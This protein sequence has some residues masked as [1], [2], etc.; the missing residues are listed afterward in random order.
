MEK[1]STEKIKCVH[2]SFKRNGLTANGKQRYRCKICGKTFTAQSTY[3]INKK[4]R[5]ALGI[6]YNL[7][8]ADFYDAPTLQKA[9]YKACLKEKELDLHEVDYDSCINKHKVHGSV[10]KYICYNPKLIVCIE[11]NK[12]KLYK[13]HPAN[14][15]TKNKSRNI[16]IQELFHKS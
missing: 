1:S 8:E 2:S 16:H 7:L 12:L 13:I 9:L 11:D 15:E 4:A 10:L 6:L 5:V 3:K 14:K